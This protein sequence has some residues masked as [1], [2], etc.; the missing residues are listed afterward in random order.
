MHPIS[1]AEAIEKAL[2]R[3]MAED[4]R[5]IIMGEDV[6]TLRRNLFVRFGRTGFVPLPSAKALLSV[7]R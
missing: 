2:A 3:A 4:P 5:I 7:R 1:F 6:H